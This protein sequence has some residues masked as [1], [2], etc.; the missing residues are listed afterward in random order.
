M[1]ENLKA[2]VTKLLAELD[3][4]NTI[5]SYK[6][7]RAA[8]MIRDLLSELTVSERLLAEARAVKESPVYLIERSYNRDDLGRAQWHIEP[9]LGVFFSADD[10]QR[11]VS[12]LEWEDKF[13]DDYTY[14]DID[15]GTVPA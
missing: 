14:T 1:H 11:M 10:A 9:H 7:E 4:S 12:H 8:R 2:E 3:D 13:G 6:N 5:S 15:P